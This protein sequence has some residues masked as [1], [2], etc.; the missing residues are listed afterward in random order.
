MTELDGKISW[1]SFLISHSYSMALLLASP[2][3][4]AWSLLADFREKYI[5]AG[6]AL[7]A[8]TVGLVQFVVRSA[9]I[10][11]RFRLTENDLT[12]S[13]LGR[14]TRRFPLTMD[15]VVGDWAFNDRHVDVWLSD[16]TTLYL[17]LEHL[18][19]ARE[20]AD[21]LRRFTSTSD[22][23]LHGCLSRSAVAMT[24]SGQLLIA[25]VLAAIAVV[26]VFI[27]GVAFHPFK[28]SNQWVFAVL[29]G[30]LLTL[31]AVGFYFFVPHYWMGC[32]RWFRLDRGVLHY[33]RLFSQTVHQ[34]LIEDM[35]LIST[36]RPPSHAAEWGSWKE[37]RFR[38]GERI[39]L[40]IGE[41]H[42]ATRLYEVFKAE[43]IRRETAARRVPIAHVPSDHHLRQ[44]VEPLL[45]MG[46][47]LYWIGI[48]VYRKLWNE[49]AAGVVFGAVLCVPGLGGLSFFLWVAIRTGEPGAYFAAAI[50]AGFAGI[51]MH[52]LATPYWCRRWMRDTVYAVT[53]RPRWS[54]MD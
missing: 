21:K 30:L 11:T 36:H 14:R 13:R 28:M 22:D 5:L 43:S 39:K 37:I 25:C 1:P 24:L 17:E 20:L 32:V 34:Q 3:I 33:G 29:G 49:M 45:Q 9:G 47:K 40:R 31:C 26:S 8:G 38:G 46:E 23:S 4:A 50:T 10:V 52:Y 51:A 54:C 18:A 19:N 6:F 41:L 35:E 2:T 27:L 16:G 42:N 7:L 12:F 53:S 48:P 44:R 15:G